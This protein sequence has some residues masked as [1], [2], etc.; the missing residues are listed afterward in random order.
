MNENQASVVIPK[1]L[2]Q[3]VIDAHVSAAIAK[4]LAGPDAIV[5]G[6]VERLCNQNVDCE[7]R[8]SSYHNDRKTWLQWAVEN[9][10]KQ[11]VQATIARELE[12]HK[13]RIKEYL[14][15]ELSKKKSP[16]VRSLVEGMCKGLVTEGLRYRLEVT[17]K[18]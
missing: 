5:K 6:I 10:L 16:L 12:G 7:G 15:D 17:A 9:M 18:E 14:A 3:P 2:L 13:E 8:P 11:A 4:A 1:E